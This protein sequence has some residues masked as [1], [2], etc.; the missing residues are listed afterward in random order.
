MLPTSDKAWDNPAQ[1]RITWLRKPCNRQDGAAGAGKSVRRLLSGLQVIVDRTEVA[2][3]EGG[4]EVRIVEGRAD[5][6]AS[7]LDVG[8]KER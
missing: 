5:R 3:V 6:F 1:Q 7:R 8:V 2:V 4:E